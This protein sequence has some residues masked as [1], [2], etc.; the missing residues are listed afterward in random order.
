MDRHSEAHIHNMPIVSVDEEFN[1]QKL[2]EL[3]GTKPYNPNA[4]GASLCPFDVFIFKA[5][6][7]RYN[8]KKAT[9]FGAGVTT[10]IMRSMGIDVTAF[11]IDVSGAGKRR[12]LGKL[13]FVKC[14]LRDPNF[15]QQILDSCMDSDLILIDCLHS[16]DMSEYYSENFLSPSLTSVF[17]H[18]MYNPT[19]NC[20]TTGEQKYMNEN[21]IGAY[22]DV[23]LYTDLRNK[24]IKRISEYLKVGV[25]AGMGRRCSMVLHSNEI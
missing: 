16:Y 18:D 2:I 12:G 22:Y 8:I 10:D 19:K 24:D 11:S 21:V 6:L 3:V 17:M 14:G 23:Y 7:K 15:K 1:Y 20:K 13:E 25:G 4:K 5:Y 9:E